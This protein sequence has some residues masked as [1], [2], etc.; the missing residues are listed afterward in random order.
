MKALVSLV[1]WLTGLTAFVVLGLAFFLLALFI[2]PRALSTPARWACRGILLGAGQWVTVEDPFPPV[3]D[4]PYVYMFNHTSL[5][6]TFIVLAV[7]PEFTGAIGK[8]EQFKVPLWG[9]ILRRWGAVPIDRKR[10]GE[11]IAS[12][13]KVEETL[14]EGTSLL[15]SPEGTRSLDG[16]L[17]AFKKG[18][19]HVA[20]N[21]KTPI[22]PMTLFGAYAAKHKGSWHIT[23][24]RLRVSV[25]APIRAREDGT[26]GMAELRAEVHAH[27]T[28]RLDQGPSRTDPLGGTN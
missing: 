10:L 26:T 18:P 6:D 20:Y 27:F 17:A 14:A 12:L 9:W 28:Q 22:V 16:R 7:I 4:G 25:G 23:P 15:I 21:T 13:G 24:G 2:P 1:L 3:A 11:A 5:F 8:R 19:F